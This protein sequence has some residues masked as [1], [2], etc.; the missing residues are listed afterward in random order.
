MYIPILHIFCV[1][2]CVFIGFYIK[3]MTITGK[4]YCG[5]FTH[6][7]YVYN[8]PIYKYQKINE[9][10]NNVVAL[11]SALFISQGS[12]IIKYINEK[13]EIILIID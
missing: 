11:G 12:F 6:H 10:N 1:C 7:I 9:N 4:I 13:P 5:H 3:V 8:T 2:K